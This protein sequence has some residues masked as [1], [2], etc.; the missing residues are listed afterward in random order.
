MSLAFSNTSTK[1]G[2]IQEIESECG[3]EDGFITGN[4]T[5]FQKVTTSINLALDDYLSV[6]IPTSGRWQF[7]DSNQTDYPIVTTNLVVGQRDYPFTI[8]TDSNLILDIYRA[9]VLVSA[10]S[11]VYEEIFPVDSQSDLNVI[12]F[13]DGQNLRGVPIRYDKTANAIF[14][15]PVPSYSATNGLK[16]YINREGSYFTTSD[17]TKKPGVPG[18]HH[19][20]FVLKG[21]LDYARRNSLA[22]LPRLEGEVLKYEGDPV[23]GLQGKI[24]KYF[25]KRAKDERSII[26]PNLEQY[27]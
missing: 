26:T 8:D 17:T 10:T 4:T 16:I 3:L 5:L 14:L 7:D 19:R 20:Y 23:R 9:F 15:D 22:N 21:A 1:K 18:L 12:G 6:A 24:A 13:T 25:S 27:V 11:T 2:I